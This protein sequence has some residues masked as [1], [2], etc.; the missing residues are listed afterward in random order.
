MFAIYRYNKRVLLFAT[1]K[2]MLYHTGNNHNLKPILIGKNRYW[3]HVTV[4]YCDQY[5]DDS[6]QSSEPTNPTNPP[7]LLTN[8]T[9][10]ADWST[11]QTHWTQI[12]TNT[13][14][15]V[16]W[17]LCTDYHSLIVVINTA[18]LLPH[19]HWAY[20]R[21][22]LSWTGNL[23]LHCST[24]LEVSSQCD[25]GQNVD[26]NVVVACPLGTWFAG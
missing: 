17:H 2:V 19:S 8:W 16:L 6:L 7:V 26:N 25:S 21:P 12:M 4:Y 9:F 15:S 5:Y 20:V 13:H 24:Q 18:C 23:L 14:N 11:D 10:L 22:H 1:V 3:Y